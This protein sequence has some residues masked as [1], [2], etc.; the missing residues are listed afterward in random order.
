MGVSRRISTIPRSFKVGEHFVLV[1]HPKAI[2]IDLFKDLN[3]ASEDVKFKPGIF[4]VFKP[5]PIE[6]ILADT[7]S[8]EEIKEWKTRL[9]G[10]PAP[11]ERQ[12]PSPNCL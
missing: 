4:H 5:S 6:K 11:S 12:S 8:P 9:Q 3:A 2:R 1:A 7:A 10:D